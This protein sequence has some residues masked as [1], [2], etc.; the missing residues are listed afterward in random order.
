MELSEFVTSLVERN[1]L[2]LPEQSDE[3]IR[4]YVDHDNFDL[5]LKCFWLGLIPIGSILVFENHTDGIRL[6]FANRD[7]GSVPIK[8]YTTNDNCKF[9][10]DEFCLTRLVRET[11]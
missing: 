5:S 11:I 8:P 1:V 6:E 4:Y 2:H 7:Y 9:N 3:D 10:Y